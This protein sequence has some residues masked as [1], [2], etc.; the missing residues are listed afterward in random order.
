[1]QSVGLG[2]STLEDRHRGAVLPHWWG[3]INAV[4]VLQCSFVEIAG[5]TLLP[6]TG[7]PKPR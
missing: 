3:G 5:F 6:Q 7:L 4:E 1:M 2:Y